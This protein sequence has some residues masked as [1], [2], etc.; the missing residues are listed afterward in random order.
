MAELDVL[1]ARLRGQDCAAARAVLDE[2]LAEQGA[3]CPLDV[4]A[5]RFGLSPFERAVLLLAAAREFGLPL[6]DHPGHDAPVTFARALALPE[7]QWSALTPAGPLRRWNL[8]HLLD[9]SSVVHSPLILDERVLH[10]LLGTDYLDPEVAALVR[11][12]DP[13]GVAAPTL[14]RAAARV[15]QAWTAG[16]GILLHG[17]QRAN[18]TATAA[19]AAE[20]AGRVLWSLDAAEL[21]AEPVERDQVLRRLERESALSGAA[22]SIEVGERAPSWLGRVLGTLDAPVLALAASDGQAAP[23]PGSAAV[24]VVA[25]GRLPVAE[26]SSTLAHSIAAAGTANGPRSGGHR[27]PAVGSEEIDSAATVFDLPVTDLT[28]VAARVAQ[29]A[30]VWEAC[31]RQG[32]RR[33]GGLARL[34]EPH[35]GW[36]D[37]VLPAATGAQL[38][39]LVDSVRQR[40]IV[41]EQWGFAA[42]NGRGL[43]SAALFAGASGTGKTLAAEVVAGE[44]GLDLLVIDLSQVVSKYIGE[45]EKHLAQVFDAAE[46]CGAVLLFDEADVLF[47][48]RTEVRDSHDRYANLEVGYLLQRVESFRGLAILTTNARTALDPAFLRR[49]RV[50]VTFPYPDAAARVALWRRAFP[51]QTPLADLDLKGLSAVD[52]P[53]GGIAA[54]ALTAAYLGADRGVVTMEDL[55]AATTWELAKNGRTSTTHR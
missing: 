54:A 23:E 3:P 36:D 7:G 50:V 10:H 18:L 1:L 34:I 52:L 47:G 9:P 21:P 55:A 12:V 37:L 19:A 13:L 17:P 28:A 30:S 46:D 6:A 2:L 29:G 45:T 4:L 35:R 49:L 14:V 39:A 38:H 31:R 51:P 27:G 44:L 43:G 8:V 41:H 11:P 40:R 24:V 5:E 53:G 42:R 32:R 20:A 25:V 15:V 48:K 22:W 26:R 33:F 16:R